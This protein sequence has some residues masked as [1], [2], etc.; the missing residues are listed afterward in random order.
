MISDCTFHPELDEESSCGS[1]VLATILEV[2]CQEANMLMDLYAKKGW[3][4]YTNVSHIRDVV[5]RKGLRMNKIPVKTLR[6]YFNNPT[7][8]FIQLEGPWEEKG[9]RSAY[10]YTHWALGY[11]I[12][13]MDINNMHYFS[14]K[15]PF[16]LP[17]MYWRSPVMNDL[18]RGTEN[19]T[20]W[21][22]RAAYEFLGVP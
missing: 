6:D 9:W 2:C 13:V 12:N 3:N 21:H 15:V 19:A 4:G 1:V 14:R 8:L 22:V 16:W 18:I 17:T 20:G 10:G 5:V 11:K 7:A